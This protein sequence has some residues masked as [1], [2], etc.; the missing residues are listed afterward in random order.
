MDSG[1]KDI[2]LYNINTGDGENKVDLC[3]NYNGG[4]YSNDDGGVDDV[5]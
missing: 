2:E 3:N 1:N 4:G 5:G